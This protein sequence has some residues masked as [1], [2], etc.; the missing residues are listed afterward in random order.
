MGSALIAPGLSDLMHDLMSYSAYGTAFSTKAV[1]TFIKSRYLL[2][3]EQSAEEKCFQ[4]CLAVSQLATRD[5]C[6]LSLASGSSQDHSII[7]DLDNSRAH[8]II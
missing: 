2:P 6:I 1:L 7:S 8:S 4:S 3:S 5:T